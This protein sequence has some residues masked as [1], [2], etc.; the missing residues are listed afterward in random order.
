MHGGPLLLGER[1]QRTAKELAPCVHQWVEQ[2]MALHPSACR[3]LGHGGPGLPLELLQACSMGRGD[4]SLFKFVSDM[5][6]LNLQTE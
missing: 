6:I 1:A 4:R 5:R 3:V 2:S